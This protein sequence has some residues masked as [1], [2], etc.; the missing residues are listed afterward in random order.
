MKK[1]QNAADSYGLLPAAAYGHDHRLRV[2]EG[3][4]VHPAMS[5]GGFTMSIEGVRMI[6]VGV[7]Q[8]RFPNHVLFIPYDV[9]PPELFRAKAWRSVK[10]SKSSKKKTQRPSLKPGEKKKAEK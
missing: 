5:Q 4:G 9:F 1:K 3:V 6:T 8:R 2:L 10:K 7:L